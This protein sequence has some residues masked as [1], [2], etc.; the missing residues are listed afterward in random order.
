MQIIMR[1]LIFF[2]FLLLPLV[3]EAQLVS[4]KGQIVDQSSKEAVPYASIFIQEL[5]LGE[6]A[7]NGGVFAFEV[8]ENPHYTL[9]IEHLGYKLWEKKIAKEALNDLQ[10]ELTSSSIIIETILVSDNP[11]RQPAQSSSIFDHENQFNRP[12]DVGDLFRDLPGFGVIKRG[13]YAMDPVLR[14][15]KNEQ[16]NIQYDGGVQVMH[17]CPNRMDPITTHVIPEEV[18]EIELIRGPFSVRYGQSFGGI[19]NIIT[20]KPKQTDQY[21]LGGSVEGGYESNGNSKLTRLSVNSTGKVYDLSF[22]GGIR[23]FGNYKN[24]DGLEIPTSFTSYDYSAKAGFNPFANHRLQL[25]WRQSFGRDILHVGLPM[26]TEEDN[27]A[28]LSVDYVVKNISPGLFSIGFKSYFSWVDHIMSNAHRPNFKVV[29][30]LANVKANTAGGKL[31]FSITPSAQWQTYLGIDLRHLERDG[32]RNRLVKKNMMTGVVLDPPKLFTD[33]IWQAASQSDIGIFAENRFFKGSDWTITFGAR[34]DMVTNNIDDPADDFSALYPDL[35][36]DPEFNLSANLSVDYQVDDAWN[37]QLALG[38]GVRTANM[39]ERYINHFSLGVDAYEYVGNPHLKPEANHQIEFSVSRRNR[40]VTLQAATFYSYITNYIT[41]SVDPEL[42]RKFMPN[43]EPTIAKRFTN[44]DAATQW[45]IELESRWKISKLF[46]VYG[47][48][49]FTH[50]QNLDWEEPLSEIPPLVS[51]M[52]L[53]FNKGPISADVRGRLVAKQNRVAASFDEGSTPGFSV[54]DIRAAWEPWERLNLGFSLLNIFNKSYYE[55]LNRGYRNTS[56]PGLI[57][58]PG[59]NFA[60]YLK[61]TF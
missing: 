26:D 39:E 14:S 13:G 41:A 2:L 11:K 27:S 42:P 61:Y 23:D 1:K 33:K 52:G 45:G 30:A 35:D 46:D 44:I 16:L 29:D 21:T 47:N 3:V 49:Q 60:A 17:A 28:I 25:G 9:K 50:A 54:F 18:E 59:R 20:Q 55:H 48:I 53:A 37:M 7:D 43:V 34:V 57:Y 24:G 15:F 5:N 51:R 38:R 31:E 10:I 36:P 56:T 4:I 22:S 12:K 58:E 32:A 8:L 19:I 6:Y 40:T